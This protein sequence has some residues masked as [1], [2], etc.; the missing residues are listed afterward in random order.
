MNLEHLIKSIQFNLNYLNSSEEG[1]ENSSKILQAIRIID[2]QFFVK[3]KSDAYIDTA[4]PIGYNQ[5]IS[6]PSTV[7]RMLL[8]ANLQSGND[9]L[10]LGSGSGWNASIIGFIVYPGKVVSMD[11][12][13]N[14]VEQAR[15]NLAK[16]EEQL[17]QANR[18]KL[19]KI[20]FQHCNIFKEVDSW[21]DTFDRI[22]ITAGIKESQEKII[23][24]LAY[25]ILRENEILV[26]PHIYGP[27]I[28]LK[29]AND[30]IMKETTTEQYVFVPL[31][32]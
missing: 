22:V 9:I 32:E 12:I 18:Q 26:C 3:H 25:K 30:K 17:S 15:Q 14:L 29:K 8:L 16:L 28:I 13:A 19:N 21:K 1:K 11:I 6:Q 10:E 24:Q 23:E 4:L 2:R 31:L 20:R 27:L 7:A 5:T